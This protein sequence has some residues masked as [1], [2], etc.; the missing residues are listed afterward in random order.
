MEK[1]QFDR[2]RYVL[3]DQLTQDKRFHF[4]QEFCPSYAT[5]R[6]CVLSVITDWH[7]NETG[8]WGIGPPYNDPNATVQ[9][10]PG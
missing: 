4:S 7:E 3:V 1:K 10:Q 6:T 8:I 5:N 2:D 9:V